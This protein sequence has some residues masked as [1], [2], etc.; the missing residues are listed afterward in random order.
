MPTRRRG[1][2][3]ARARNSGTP[4]STPMIR[5]RAGAGKRAQSGCGPFLKA[6][7]NRAWRAG[8]VKDDRVWRALKLF[9]DVDAPRVRYLSMAY[10]RL[11]GTGPPAARLHSID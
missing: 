2:G 8:M 4:K 10:G 6:A 1:C 11:Q 3:H 7:L 9:E 5:R